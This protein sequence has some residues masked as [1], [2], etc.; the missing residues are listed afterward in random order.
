MKQLLS[1][2][3]DKSLFDEMST[4]FRVD[5]E[6]NVTGNNF[7]S[8]KLKGSDLPS[9]TEFGYPL[10]EFVEFIVHQSTDPYTWTLECAL[11]ES[12]PCSHSTRCISDN[13]V[14]VRFKNS[15]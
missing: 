14:Q 3:A 5:V 4:V 1:L 2:I 8:I 9:S 15:I 11:K 12:L 13:R 7:H 10:D 6:K